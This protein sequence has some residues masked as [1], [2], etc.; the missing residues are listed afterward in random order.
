[1]KIA[2]AILAGGKA[3]RLN[4]IAKGNIEINDNTI[5][6]NLINAFNDAGISEIAISA[7]DKKPYKQY[8]K[9]IIAD[10]KADAGPLAGIAAVL[11]Q[12]K[13]FDAVIFMPCDLPFI[14]EHEI[15]GLKNAIINSQLSSLRKRGSSHIIYAKTTT[16]AHPLCVV[17][18]TNMT[19]VITNQL[20]KGYKRKSSSDSSSLRKRG[21]RKVVKILDPRFRKDDNRNRKDDNGNRKDD[22]KK[23]FLNNPKIIAVWQQLNAKSIQCS[24]ENKFYNI[25]TPA[26]LWVITGSR[27]GAGKTTLAHKLLQILPHSIYAKYGHGKFNPK[28]QKNFFDDLDKLHDFIA[29]NKYLKRN[30]IIEANAL[31]LADIGDITIF[32]DAPPNKIKLRKDAELLKNKA[33]IVISSDA[34]PEHWHKILSKHLLPEVILNTAVESFLQQKKFL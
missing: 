28:K 14:T 24:D 1:M 34:N 3:K 22:R 10:F 17:I 25:N 18:P 9:T 26:L 32:I 12:L 20:N 5:I 6:A 21:S 29:Q 13:Q 16:Q 15:L 19:V 11:Q 7:N 23:R 31:A 33:D 8:G 30:I 27:R 2:G 4:G